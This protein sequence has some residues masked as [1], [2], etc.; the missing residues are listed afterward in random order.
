MLNR[1]DKSCQCDIMTYMKLKETRK[2][3]GLTAEDMAKAMKMSSRNW[4]KI[5]AGTIGFDV[6]KAIKLWK[7]LVKNGMD[8]NTNLVDLF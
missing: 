7:F 3:L 4:L 5:E 8:K 6:H 2:Q 1:L